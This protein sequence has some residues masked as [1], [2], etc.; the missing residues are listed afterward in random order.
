VYLKEV[1]DSGLALACIAMME[2]YKVRAARDGAEGVIVF[3]RRCLKNPD[4]DVICIARRQTVPV[5][6]L[7]KYLICE[8]PISLIDQDYGLMQHPARYIKPN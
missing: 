3:W 1:G 8:K 4:C 5:D 6:E 2:R 7:G